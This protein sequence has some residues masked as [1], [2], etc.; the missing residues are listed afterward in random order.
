MDEKKCKGECGCAEVGDCPP[1]S[2]TVPGDDHEPSTDALLTKLKQ[3]SADYENFRNRS[4]RE[5][6]RMYDMGKMSVVESLLPIVDNFA[7]ATKNADGNDGFVKGVA[8]I[9]NQLNHM[10]DELGVKR[11]SAVGEVFDIKFHNAVSHIEDESVGEK[12]IVEELQAGYTYKDT[13][14]RH[15]MVVVAN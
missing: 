5:K 4:E 14:L 8:M 13:V 10:L 2:G 6:T 12:V 7:L 11:I 9:Q 3:I 15:S 1:V